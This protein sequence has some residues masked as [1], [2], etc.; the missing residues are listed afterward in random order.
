MRPLNELYEER[1][2]LEKEIEVLKMLHSHVQNLIDNANN[3]EWAL[4]QAAYWQKKA[5]EQPK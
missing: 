4:T 3:K 2:R 5:Q 1:R